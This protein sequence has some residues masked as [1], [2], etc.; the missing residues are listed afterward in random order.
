MAAS[1]L[2]L[3]FTGLDYREQPWWAWC[4]YANSIYTDFWTRAYLI[5]SAV[6]PAIVICCIVAIAIRIGFRP[7]ATA[8]LYGDSKFAEAK[9]MR[10]NGVHLLR[11]F[12][13]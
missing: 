4:I 5:V 7:R 10:R 1:A 11:G 12:F 6:I 8:P 9:E 3:H 13:R 2:F